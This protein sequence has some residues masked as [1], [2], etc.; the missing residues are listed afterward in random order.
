MHKIAYDN[1]KAA[2]NE[3]YPRDDLKERKLQSKRKPWET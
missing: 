1:F 2:I 3:C